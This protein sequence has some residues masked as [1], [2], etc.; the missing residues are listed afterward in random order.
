MAIAPTITNA[1]CRLRYVPGSC[2][3]SLRLRLVAE[4][5]IRSPNAVR[6]RA[7]RA[8]VPSTWRGVGRSV[9]RARPES[10]TSISPSSPHRL[11]HRWEASVHRGPGHQLRRFDPEQPLQHPADHRGGRGRTV[12][13]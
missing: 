12:A 3:N 13:G 4:Y 9:V 8:R 11:D 7:A 5:T 2:P 1:A 6:A 10:V